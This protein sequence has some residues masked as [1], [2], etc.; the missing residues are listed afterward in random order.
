[1]VQ[2]LHLNKILEF[3][4]NHGRTWL[5]YALVIPY[6]A[7]TNGRG[8]SLCTHEKLC[9][10]VVQSVYQRV[11]CL[12]KRAGLPQNKIDEMVRF[13]KTSDEHMIMVAVPGNH[14]NAFSNSFTPFAM[15][16]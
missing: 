13:W 9:F 14:S 6:I 15:K 10:S 1:M 7:I 12:D 11:P 8:N 4:L 16:K 3:L 5:V 2:Y